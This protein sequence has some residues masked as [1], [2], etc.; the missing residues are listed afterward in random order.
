MMAWLGMWLSDKFGLWTK[1]MIWKNDYRFR[2]EL[3][4]DEGMMDDDIEDDVEL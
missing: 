4:E 3:N 2:M 1:M